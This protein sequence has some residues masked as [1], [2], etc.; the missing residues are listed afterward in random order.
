MAL[1][2]TDDFSHA[3]RK[4]NSAELHVRKVEAANHNHSLKYEIAYYSS[5]PLGCCIIDLWMCTQHLNI[6][7]SLKMCPR[8]SLFFRLL[9]GLFLHCV[10]LDQMS[11]GSQQF[12]LSE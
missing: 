11:R 7:S 6:V 5:Q 10:T 3:E 8:L 9:V 1:K 2:K 4:I 12:K